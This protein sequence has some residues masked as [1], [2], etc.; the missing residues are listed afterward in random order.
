PRPVKVSAAFV[1]G[2]AIATTVGVLV[3]LALVSLLGN[4]VSLGRSSNGGSVGHAIQY[5]LVGLLIAAAIRNYLQRETAQP[6]RWMGALQNADP[7]RAFMTGLLL[8]W[9]MPSDLVI[10]VTVGVNLAHSGA[11]PVA[12]LPFVAATTLVAALP[13]LAYLLFR[14]RAQRLTPKVR[15]WMNTNSWLVNIIAYAAFIVLILF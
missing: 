2:V 12:A 3:A 1:A 5:V 14:R 10:M 6:P 9:V 13:M 15:D 11:S 4:S 7:R 8:I